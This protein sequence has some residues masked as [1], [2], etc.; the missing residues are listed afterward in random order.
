MSRELKF[1]AWDKKTKSWYHWPIQVDPH[2]HPAKSD[3]ICQYTGL[4]DKNGTEIYEGDRLKHR[5]EDD[6]GVSLDDELVV[7]WNDA[8]YWSTTEYPGDFEVIGNIYE[9]N[10]N[11]KPELLK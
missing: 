5:Y 3:A 11:K 8:G 1:R 2:I 6:E 7:E 9:G 4:K 10:T